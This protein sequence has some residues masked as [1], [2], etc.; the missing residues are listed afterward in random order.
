MTIFIQDLRTEVL[1]RLCDANQQIWQEAEVDRYIQDGYD[2]LTRLTGCVF[3]VT[4]APVSAS[5]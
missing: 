1:Q 2:V 4:F 5:I 3:G